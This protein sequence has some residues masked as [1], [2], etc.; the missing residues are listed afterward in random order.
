MLQSI[1]KI[2]KSIDN[3]PMKV[4][5]GTLKSEMLYRIKCNDEATYVKL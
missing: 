4:F 1:S 3:W 2:G 5:C